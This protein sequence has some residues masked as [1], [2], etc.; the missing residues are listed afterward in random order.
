MVDLRNL[1]ML[2]KFDIYS[3]ARRPDLVAQLPTLG[4]G[5]SQMVAPDVDAAQ[6]HFNVD[7]C[8]LTMVLLVEDQ[9]EEVTKLRL[10]KIAII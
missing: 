2:K 3:K 7:G 10:G 5:Y 8:T 6:F 4:P 1:K 9:V